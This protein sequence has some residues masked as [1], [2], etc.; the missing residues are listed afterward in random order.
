MNGEGECICVA[1]ART[2]LRCLL[3][4]FG[5]NFTLVGSDNSGGAHRKKVKILRVK[6]KHTNT[7]QTIDG[8]KEHDG[9]AKK[10]KEEKQGEHSYKLFVW[11]VAQQCEVA[12]DVHIGQNKTERLTIGLRTC[13][14][15]FGVPWLLAFCKC[16]NTVERKSTKENKPISDGCVFRIVAFWL[17]R[18]CQRNGAVHQKPNSHFGNRAIASFARISLWDISENQSACHTYNNPIVFIPRFAGWASSLPPHIV[19]FMVVVI[20]FFSFNTFTR[21]FPPKVI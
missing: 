14:V 5:F 6:M 18:Q 12:H 13:I 9:P 3:L 2:R 7:V 20:F 1:R 10:K 8:T 21:N 16:W 17:V 15:F 19:S 11:F 4:C